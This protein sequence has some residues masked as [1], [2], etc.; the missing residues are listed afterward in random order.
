MIIGY[1]S[2]NIGSDDIRLLLCKQHQQ[3]A[4]H[5]HADL[6]RALSSAYMHRSCTTAALEANTSAAQQQHYHRADQLHWSQY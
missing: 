6:L 3:G 4:T 1:S 5:Q 2:A